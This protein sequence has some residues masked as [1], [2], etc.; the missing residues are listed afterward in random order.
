MA[1][2]L[3]IDFV[4]DIV[5]PWCIIGLKGL[6]VALKRLDGEV[7]ADIRFHPFELNPDME[8]QGQNLG[9]HLAQKYG[10]TPEQSA[11]NRAM[12]KDRAAALGFD[13]TM[14]ADSRMY[15]SFDAHRLLCWAAEEGGQ[16]DL[17]LAMFEAYFT[18]GLNVADHS[19]LLGAVAKAGLDIE[20]ALTILESDEFAAAVRSEEA[21]W[22]SRGI[23]SVPAVVVNGKYL[24]SGGQP[25]EAFEQ[26]LRKIATESRSV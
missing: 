18:H 2:R 8:P 5:C 20:R 13:I 24:I 17:K 7:T 1:E 4:S 10:S 12:I 9:E 21:L 25:P 6:Q 14:T 19:V 22:Q 23:N 3:K 15:N 11:A 16:A 26:A